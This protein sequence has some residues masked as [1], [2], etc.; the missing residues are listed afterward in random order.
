[1]LK[2]H[3]ATF[4]CQPA[5]NHL[6]PETIWRYCKVGVFSGLKDRLGVHLPSKTELLHTHKKKPLR[7]A[8]YLK[9]HIAEKV[10]QFICRCLFYKGT[11]III[12]KYSDSKGNLYCTPA[13]LLHC[14]LL[15][16]RVAYGGSPQV[17]KKKFHPFQKTGFDVKLSNM[18]HQKIQLQSI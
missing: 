3:K 16:S 10:L 11:K 6:L 8:N 2:D 9:R 7:D 14:A 5:Q 12:L 18:Q 13:V 4:L 1:M 17:F 15:V